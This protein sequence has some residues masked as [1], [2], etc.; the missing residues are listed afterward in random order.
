MNHLPTTHLSSKGDG[1]RVPSPP[2]IS[3]VSARWDRVES[4]WVDA[5]SNVAGNVPIPD[6]YLFRKAPSVVRGASNRP[7]LAAICPK[8]FQKPHFACTRAGVKRENDTGWGMSPRR[9]TRRLSL[10]HI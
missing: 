2:V 6:I 5:I 7:F 4:R 8:L 1:F 9:T 3:T 10:I